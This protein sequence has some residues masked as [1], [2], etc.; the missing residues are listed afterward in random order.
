MKFQQLALTKENGRNIC[1]PIGGLLILP[2]SFTRRFG[3]SFVDEDLEDGLGPARIALVQTAS[4]RHFALVHYV[5]HPEPRGISVWTHE[6][7]P[8]PAA[9]L[10]DFMEAFALSRED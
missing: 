1:L 9:D 7:S 5:M 8:N 10:H 2:E 3:V 4:G 6:L